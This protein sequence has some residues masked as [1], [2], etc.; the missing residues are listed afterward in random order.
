MLGTCC[1]VCA[2]SPALPHAASPANQGKRTWRARCSANSR[3]LITC[4]RVQ[5]SREDAAAAAAAALAA[6]WAPPA[7]Q[8]GSDAGSLGLDTFIVYHS[9]SGNMLTPANLGGMRAARPKPC[10]VC[11]Q[12]DAW[13]GMHCNWLP[14]HHHALGASAGT[15]SVHAAAN[16]YVGKK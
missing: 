3:F 1:A 14:V 12:R 9:K 4:C 2:Q 15:P 7:Q 5:T 10:P 16:I 8:Q 6:Q 11:C 13:E